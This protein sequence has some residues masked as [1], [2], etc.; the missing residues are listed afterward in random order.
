MI[1]NEEIFWLNYKW[2]YS[3]L[4]ITWRPTETAAYKE[5]AVSL[6]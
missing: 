2:L 3:D 6:K 5:Y 4:N 1:K